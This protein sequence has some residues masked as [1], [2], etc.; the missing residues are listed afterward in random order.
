MSTLQVCH[1][2]YVAVTIDTLFV[3]LCKVLCTVDARCCQSHLDISFILRIRSPLILLFMTSRSR[4]GFAFSPEKDQC[5]SCGRDIVAGPMGLSRHLARSPLCAEDYEAELNP[6]REHVRFPSMLSS[7]SVCPV[8]D[9]R[10]SEVDFMHTISGSSTVNDLLALPSEDVS[11]GIPNKDDA[12]EDDFPISHDD[13]YDACLASETSCALAD[14][15]SPPLLPAD[16]G[17][18]KNDVADGS[19]LDAFLAHSES[20]D[21]G[22]SL[23]LFSVEEKVQID[24]LQT[25]KRLRAP[26][27]AYEEIMRWASRSCLQGYSFRDVPIMSRK[28]VIDNIKVRVDVKSLQPLVKQLY[29]PYSKCFVEVVYFSAHSIFGSFLSCTDLNQDQNYIFNDD[30]N[31]DCNPFAKPN[32]AVI[33]DINTGAAYLKTYDALIKNMEED[34]LLP[35]ILAIDKTTCDVG[36]GGRLSLEPIVISYGLM[37]HDVRKTPR[38]MRVL[39]FINTSPIVLRGEKPLNAPTPGTGLSQPPLERNYQSQSVTDAAWRLNEYHMQIDCILRESGYLDLQ[40]TGLKWN[41]SFRGKS[42]PVVLHPFIP[43]IIGDTEGHDGLCGHYKSRTGGVAQLCRACECPTMVCGYSKARDYA[44]RKPKIINKLVREKKFPELRAM[45]Q[46]YLNNA[47]DNVRLG[48]HNDRGIFGACPGEILHLILIGWFRNVIDSFFIQISKDSVPSK[49]YDTLLLD[50]NKWLRRQSDRNVPSTSTKKGF[51][52]TAKIPGHEYAGCLFVMLISFYTSRFREIFKK[53]RAS[54][55]VSDKDKA[56]SHPGFVKDWRT[57]VSS[58]LEWHAWLKQ[59]EIRRTSVVK[60]V[61]ATSHLMRLLRYVAPRLTGGMKSNTIKTHLVLHIHEDILNFGVPEV[62]NSS[63]A[64]S[65]HITICKDTTRN[66][67]KQSQ[68]FTV[69][70]ALRYVENLAINRASIASV[71][72]TR[73]TDSVSGSTN[74]A[75][76]CGKHF[77]VYKNSDGETRCHRETS[78]KKSKDSLSEPFPLDAHVLET[79]SAHCLPHVNSQVLHCYTEYRHKGESQLYRANPMYDGKPWFDHALVSWKDEKGGTFHCPARVHAFVD[80]H[81]V[82]PR[83]SIAFPHAQQG[84]HHTKPGFYAIIE[85]YDY[86]PPPTVMGADGKPIVE[87]DFAFAI[88]RMARMTLIPNTKKPILYL[89]HTDSIMG[90]TV[91][92]PDAF[93]DTPPIVGGAS[94]PDVDY[95]FLYLPQCEW[96]QTWEANVMLKHRDA[97]GPNGYESDDAAYKVQENGEVVYIGEHFDEVEEG[98][99][100]QDGVEEPATSTRKRKTPANITQAGKAPGKNAKTR[101]KATNG[102]KPLTPIRK[103][104]SKRAS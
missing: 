85:S 59:P 66:T 24:L 69:Q 21:D 53:A 62:M 99:V 36:G 5:T 46:Q 39:G 67:Q 47:F 45:S 52:S 95:I 23:S 98:E 19:I 61:Y 30:N 27:I 56:L 51:S 102:P 1:R 34:M 37:K 13:A 48:M 7:S 18:T 54:L 14:E 32:G 76:L 71:D 35:C 4:K 74:S 25:L 104:P 83:C 10:Q 58:L 65:G 101:K 89:V 82:L 64:E 28:G 88:F 78:S 100:E 80:L 50:I 90:P 70:A 9:G 3:T 63:Y 81:D 86:L 94:N 93:G 68:T 60:S 20:I 87:D 40:R 33:S 8:D 6:R 26:L 96:S 57:L 79:L 72:S 38:A 2:L 43:F 11:E 29:L 49:K 44:R 92:I 41:L 75:K 97:T 77:I 55:K 22:L 15:E 73:I 42:F 84:G 12:E 103:P 17:A 16:D 91:G 31:P